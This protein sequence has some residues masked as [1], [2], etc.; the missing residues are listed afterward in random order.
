MEESTQ[1]NIKCPI[2]CESDEVI[3]NIILK[4]GK[5]KPKEKQEYAQDILLETR[6]LLKCSNYNVVNT[7]CLNCHS[8]AR[9]YVKEYGYLAKAFS[10]RDISN[11]RKM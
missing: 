9:K 5:V 3:K 2:F 4:V 6:S 10:A 11:S 8:I 7:D 1:N